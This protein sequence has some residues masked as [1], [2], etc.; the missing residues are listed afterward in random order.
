M[1]CVLMYTDVCF[2]YRCILMQAWN[3]CLFICLRKLVSKYVMSNVLDTMLE[4]DMKLY[5]THNSQ[6]QRAENN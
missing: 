2:V 3:R 1:F 5:I 6:I 4:Y